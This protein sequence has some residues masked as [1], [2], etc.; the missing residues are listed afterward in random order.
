MEAL[1][2]GAGVGVGVEPRMRVAVAR[3]EILEPEHVGVVGAADDH[4]AAAAAL[5]QPDAAQDQR[6]HDPLAKLGLGD[7]QRAEPLGRDDQRL[8]RSP[9]MA[10]DQR[11]APRQLAKLAHEAADAVGDDRFA[12]AKLAML[13]DLDLTR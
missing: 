6:A 1:D 10:V 3:Q 5:D 7:Q 9:G 2:E 13:A 11:R 8:D 12:P 4:R